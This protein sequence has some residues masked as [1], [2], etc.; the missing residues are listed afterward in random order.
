MIRKKGRYKFDY[1]GRS[2]VWNFF[3]DVSVRIASVDKQFSVLYEL[4][5][6][7]CLVAVSGPEFIGIA[8]TVRRPVWIVPPSVDRSDQ[9]LFEKSWNGASIPTTR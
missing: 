1:N 3:Q 2:F 8:R 9:P 7:N 4:I 6:N 5:G